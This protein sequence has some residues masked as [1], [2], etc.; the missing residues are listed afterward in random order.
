MQFYFT[1]LK[2]WEKIDIFQKVEIN[3]EDDLLRLSE[4]GFLVVLWLH[5]AQTNKFGFMR[6]TS[7][8]FRVNLV[9]FRLLLR[10]ISGKG[11]IR[12]S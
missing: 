12:Y 11:I 4:E 10:F 3:L 9:S 6:K 1:T 5:S 8:T 2:C 7:F